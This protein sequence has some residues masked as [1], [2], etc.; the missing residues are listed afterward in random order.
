MS[1]RRRVALGTCAQLTVKASNQTFPL[2]VDLISLNGRA[3]DDP[4]AI[5]SLVNT[6]GKRVAAAQLKSLFDYFGSDKATHD[7]HL[8]Y[9]SIL[10]DRNSVTNL[11]E[12]GIGTNNPDVVSHMGRRGR[13][14][15]SL[16]AF[17]DFLPQAMIYGAD[18]DSRILFEEDRIKTFLLDQTERESWGLLSAAVDHDFD[19]IIDDGLHSPN[20]NIATLLFGLER[21][22]IGGWLVVEDIPAVALP[23]WQVILTLLPG[24]YE[25][26][27]IAAWVALLFLVR[28]LT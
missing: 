8:L 13:P 5:E 23:L 27:I 24:Q 7:Y 17:R 21:L 14:G 2:I 16:R 19:L 20:A 10:A 4:V 1:L 11:L 25:A 6:E 15:A 28:R 26:R 18:I 12:I 9:G 3:I 22:K